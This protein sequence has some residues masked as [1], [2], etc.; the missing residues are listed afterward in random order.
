LIYKN[1]NKNKNSELNPSF[2]TGF[3]DGEGSFSFSVVKSTSNTTGWALLLKFNLVAANNPAN[4]T[5]LVSIQQ[6]FGI[7]KIVYSKDNTYIRFIV[8]GLKNCLIIKQHFI[9]YP[10]LSYKLVHFNI[11]CE[12]INLILSKE[13]LNLSGLLKIIALKEHSPNGLSDLLLND[14]P[15]YNSIK[16]PKYNPNF[17]LLNINW[18]AGFINADGSFGLNVQTDSSGGTFCR[19]RI[20]ITQHNNSL[21]LLQ[22]ICENL[23][24]G[25]VYSSTNHLSNIK[26]FSLNNVNNFISK[27]KVTQLLGAKALDYADFCKGIDII[28][29]KA[30]LNKEGLSTYIK[31]LEGMNSKRSYFG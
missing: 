6:F 5:M 2:V 11:W 7:G 3:T 12:V 28:N 19:F 30:H 16:K 26:N 21:A 8:N 31:N 13:H 20:L 18:L 10:L 29:S 22:A 17:A 1:K 24:V 25:K 15:N 9:N 23:G 27:F 4:Y 14:F